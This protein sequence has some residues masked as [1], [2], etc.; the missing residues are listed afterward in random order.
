MANAIVASSLASSRAASPAKQITQ[1][2]PPPPSRRSVRGK[3]HFFHPQKDSS[4]TPS[5]VKLNGL[6]TTMRKP[7][8]EEEVDEGEKRRTKKHNIMKKHPN[9]HAEGDRKRWRDAVTEKERKRYEAVWASNR[10]LH[11]FP[12]FEGSDYVVCS[13]VVKDIFTRSRLHFD[14]LEEVYTLV[15]RRKSGFLEREEFVVGLWLIDQRL[16]GRK[17]PMRVSDHVWRSVEGLQ[18]IK[19]KKAYRG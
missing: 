18:G 7:R 5:P 4:R 10:G 16:K 6:R 14:V 8:T 2:P 19:V 13:L 3:E 11:V 1:P 15:D 12:T 9:K 17:L